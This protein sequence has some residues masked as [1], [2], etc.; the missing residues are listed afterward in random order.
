M[1]ELPSSIDALPLPLPRQ[2]NPLT[3]PVRAFDNRVDELLGGLRGHPVADRLFYGASEV[4]DFSLVWHL[5]GAARGL[6]SERKADEAIRLSA[7][8]GAESLLVNG[9]IKSFFR[10]TRPPWEV[11]RAYKIRKPRSSSFP[12]GHASAAFT[13]ATVM[14]EDNP[15][16]PLWYA[17]AAVVATSRAYVKIHHASDVVAG[18]ATGIV[19]GRIARRAWPKPGRSGNAAHRS[20]H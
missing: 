4:G 12:S 17:A 16:W 20:G 8:L 7:I 6:L 13:A 1:P 19:I 15:A 3:A 10:R 2:H 11:Q 14:A 9:V 18:A 5:I